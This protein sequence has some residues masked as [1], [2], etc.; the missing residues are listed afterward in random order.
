M[1]CLN[2]FIDDDTGSIVCVVGAH[3]YKLTATS[4]RFDSAPGIA[5]VVNLLYISP[6]VTGKSP[7]SKEAPNAT[8]YEEFFTG[9]ALDLWR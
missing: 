1:Y 9:A 7:M 5:I 4:Q 8:W 3:I 2:R 6:T